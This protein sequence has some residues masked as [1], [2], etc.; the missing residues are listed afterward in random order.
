MR[1][2]SF[3]NTDASSPLCDTAL[4]AAHLTIQTPAAQRALETERRRVLCLARWVQRRAAVQ[5]EA[6]ERSFATSVTE[7]VSVVRSGAHSAHR[8][9]VR[10]PLVRAAR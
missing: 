9:L 4:P 3:G 1:F 5:V 6:L 7:P 8:H 2:L 10:F